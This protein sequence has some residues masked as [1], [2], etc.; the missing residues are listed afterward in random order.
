[1]AVCCSK[2]SAELL[3]SSHTPSTPLHITSQV[4]YLPA[5]TIALCGCPQTFPCVGHL[6]QLRHP[7]WYPQHLTTSAGVAHGRQWWCWGVALSVSVPWLFVACVLTHNVRSLSQ[8]TNGTMTYNKTTL[9]INNRCFLYLS[10]VVFSS[11][12][13]TM[14]VLWHPPFTASMTR[15]RG[16]WKPT[17]PFVCPR[18]DP[19]MRPPLHEWCH[20]HR[21]NAG[22]T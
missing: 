17:L 18:N 22:H 21:G 16:G 12:T 4:K 9:N 8:G 13:W 11:C 14:C 1:M 5:K 6:K 19:S 10:T 15:P 20:Q 7:V 3:R 2:S